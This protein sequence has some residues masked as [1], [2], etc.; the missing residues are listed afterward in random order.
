MQL[1]SIAFCCLSTGVFRYPKEEACHVAVTTVRNWLKI[2]DNGIK[3]IFNTFLDEDR[4]LY[5]R[6]LR[7]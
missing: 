7:K 6:E 4:G 3:V 2:N 1:Q 5:E